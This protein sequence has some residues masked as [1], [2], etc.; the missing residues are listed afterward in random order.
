MLTQ[1]PSRFKCFP[2]TLPIWNVTIPLPVSNVTNLLSSL[3]SLS[4]MLPTPYPPSLLSQLLQKA[5]PSLPCHKCYQL[6]SLFPS[7][8]KFGTNLLHPYHPWLKCYQPLAL[9]SLPIANLMPYP[10]PCL[11]CCKPFALPPL[12]VLN[13]TNPL[14]FPLPIRNVINLLSSLPSL[15]LPPPCLNCYHPLPSLPFPSQMPPGPSHPASKVTTL[16]WWY[17]YPSPTITSKVSLNL[18][19][20]Y[21][22]PFPATKPSL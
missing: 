9:S 1:S 3:P 11:K 17:L 19:H 10:P 21:N 13:V 22:L 20:K 7:L 18:S 5:L 15:A 4:Q 14:P 8:S 2:L 16:P 12:P 6:L